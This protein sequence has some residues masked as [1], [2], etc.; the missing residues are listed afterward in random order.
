MP[1][2]ITCGIGIGDEIANVAYRITAPGVASN[3][4]LVA[5]HDLVADATLIDWK[6][7]A[8][9]EVKGIHVGLQSGQQS[10]YRV[11]LGA[12]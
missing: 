9:D 12:A 2:A 8:L 3:R 6:S 10:P 11:E 7:L 4:I 1:V 5:N